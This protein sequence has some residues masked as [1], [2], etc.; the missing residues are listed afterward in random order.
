M[1]GIVDEKILARLVVARFM[2]LQAEMRDLIAQ[3]EKEMVFTVMHQVTIKD[4]RFLNKLTIFTNQFQTNIERF[5][6]VNSHIQIMHRSCA[7]TQ[8]E[9][10][11]MF[12]RQD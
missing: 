9:A 10:A 1:H 4:Q 6:A 7:E 12:S 2:M 8:L 11:K 5:I 3:N